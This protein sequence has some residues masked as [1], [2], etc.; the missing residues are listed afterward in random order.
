[1]PPK[2]PALPYGTTT[3]VETSELL[4]SPAVWMATTYSVLVKLKP[5]S[6]QL[7]LPSAVVEPT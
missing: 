7:P 4:P 3:A 2:T 1:M 5:V 6:D